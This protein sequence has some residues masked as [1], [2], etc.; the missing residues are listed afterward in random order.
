MPKLPRVAATGRAC[1]GLMLVAWSLLA[2]GP[3]IGAQDRQ[4]VGRT[5]SAEVVRVA[6]G[7][8]IEVRTAA[9]R[10]VIRIRVHGVDAPERG[11]PFSQ[12]ATRF[13][14]AA[15]F[16]RV[17]TLDGQDVDRYGRLV[18]RVRHGRMDLGVELVRAGLACHYRRYA[19][20]PALARGEAEARAAGRG[21]W[22]RGTAQPACVARA[23]GLGVR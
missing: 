23:P 8:S 16:G 22:A 18:A 6:D 15:V 9:G 10:E 20:D 14:R 3:P 11:E 1:T 19:S 2:A 7:D 13:T 5:F 4:L 17:V 21:V 12:A